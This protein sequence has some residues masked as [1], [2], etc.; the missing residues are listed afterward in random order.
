[1][2]AL[3]APRKISRRQELRQD[4]V[5]TAY[6][7]LSNAFREYR[8]YALAAASVIVVA[9]IG[10]IGYKAYIANQD[11]KAAGEL[12]AI[13]RVYEAGRYDEAV[14]GNAQ[15]PGLEEIIGKYSGTPSANL[16]HFYAGDALFRLGNKEE[17]LRHFEQFDKEDNYLG[18]SALAAEAAIQEDLGDLERSADLYREAATVF[19]NSLTSPDLLL[20]AARNYEAIGNYSA[21][22][23][24]YETISTLYPDSD[25]AAGLDF[26]F[27]RLDALQGRL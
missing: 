23:E 13:V 6:A 9:V 5:V 22:R 7:R 17:A 1:M 25:L 27:A 2:P 26:Y 8:V 4:A 21:A 19:E 16:A 11:T 3:Q 12:G 18:A 14:E 10:F 24:M 15:N 20:S